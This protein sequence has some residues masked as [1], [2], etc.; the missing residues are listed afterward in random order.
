MPTWRNMTYHGNE[1]GARR[2]PRRQG[3]DRR[4]GYPS[5]DTANAGGNPNKKPKPRRSSVTIRLFTHRKRTAWV[6]NS[7]A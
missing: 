7:C 4:P 2:H 5:Q 6:L 1:T 3:Q